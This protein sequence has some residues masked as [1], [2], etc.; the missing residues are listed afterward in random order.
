MP[1]RMQNASE[2]YCMSHSTTHATPDT[3][4]EH[5]DHTARGSARSLD[6]FLDTS[7]GATHR[8]D[9][10]RRLPTIRA[11]RRLS[12]AQRSIER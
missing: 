7:R 4:E 8:S 2:Q 1:M 10:P 6:S 12:L 11:R 5:T 3:K 9:L